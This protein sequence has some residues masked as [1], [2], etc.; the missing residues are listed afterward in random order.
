[1]SDLTNEI[2]DDS[3]STSH[4][5]DGDNV[6][7]QLIGH[8][9]A[10]STQHA[11]SQ[12]IG[13]NFT[14]SDLDLAPSPGIQER[15]EFL[16]N[17]HFQSIAFEDFQ[18]TE[19]PSIAQTS[20]LS[21]ELHSGLPI[22]M[23]HDASRSPTGNGQQSANVF[24][25]GQKSCRQTNQSYDSARPGHPGNPDIRPAALQTNSFYSSDL[26]SP[27]DI[28]PHSQQFGYAGSRASR[29][30]PIHIQQPGQLQQQR[31]FQQQQAHLRGG[32][33]ASSH[34]SGDPSQVR[35]SPYGRDGH[36]SNNARAAASFEADR[37]NEGFGDPHLQ[38]QSASGGSRNEPSRSYQQ[39][40]QINP[41]E[42]QRSLPPQ[43]YGPQNYN[44][45][46]HSQYTPQFP[47]G[48]RNE[49]SRS[50]RQEAQI[51]PGGDQR[52]LPPQTYG[53]QNYNAQSHSQQIAQFPT[54][55]QMGGENP[56]YSSAFRVPYNPSSQ[57]AALQHNFTRQLE[58]SNPTTRQLQQFQFG[59]HAHPMQF[60]PHGGRLIDDTHQNQYYG[61]GSGPQSV[62]GMQSAH[63]LTYGP[64]QNSVS[65]NTSS[66]SYRMSGDSMWSDPRS[67]TTS[68]GTDPRSSTS[69]RRRTQQDDGL[70]ED[71]KRQVFLERNRAAAAKCRQKK[72]VADDELQAKRSIV[73]EH[74]KQLKAERERLVGEYLRYKNEI[75]DHVAAGC[76]GNELSD[77]VTS[78]EGRRRMAKLLADSTDT[79]QINALK[80]RLVANSSAPR[81]LTSRRRSRQSSKTDDLDDDSD[82]AE[83]EE[84][85]ERE[86]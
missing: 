63:P 7:G 66:E 24:M 19:N 76:T 52:S 33:P 35:G 26:I 50:Y 67:S 74:N 11:G 78:E 83:D 61:G 17:N 77:M 75:L 46:S 62:G 53:P 29:F 41:G 42:D 14:H 16:S 27:S 12:P 44:A 47:T 28:S 31:L 56:A 43:T 55:S 37:L 72:K 58:P 9:E 15:A 80:A 30:G 36:G 70:D 4:Q 54:G 21:N 3:T 82:G 1:M 59:Q 40:A 60:G 45:Q 6:V 64:I 57:A 51:N 85:M 23:P 86:G 25:H 84:D 5:V 8:N 68:M 79:P 71:Q 34:S 81:Q 20:E 2:S 32:S 73:E 13:E 10:I 48:S 49:P 18:H 39:E 38:R 65:T 22:P 69:S